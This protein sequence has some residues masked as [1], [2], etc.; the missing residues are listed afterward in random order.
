[1]IS[2]FSES[3][4]IEVKDI[5]IIMGTSRDNM[6]RPGDFFLETNGTYDLNDPLAN[7]ASMHELV[8]GL[9]KQYK[10]AQKQ[11]KVEAKQA[12]K[13]ERNKLREEKAQ[14]FQAELAKYNAD[15]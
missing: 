13:A 5:H 1:M 3:V 11:K 4:N 12:R 6:S 10:E 8:E 15:P 14:K 2:L 9:Q 7:I